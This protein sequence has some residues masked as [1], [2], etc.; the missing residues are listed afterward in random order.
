LDH[1]RRIRLVSD[2]YLLAELQRLGGKGC[3]GVGVLF[4][5]VRDREKLRISQKERGA[6]KRC[7]GLGGRAG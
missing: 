5:F 6:A 4:L 1:A 2:E 3:R 7:G